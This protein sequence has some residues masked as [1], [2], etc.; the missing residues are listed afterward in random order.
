MHDKRKPMGQR[1]NRPVRVLLL[2]GLALCVMSC[3]ADARTEQQIRES[4]WLGA[5]C[6]ED[7]LSGTGGDIVNGLV[8][9]F[10]PPDN[11]KN[12][13]GQP[14]GCITKCLLKKDVPL[15]CAMCI[16]GRA[17]CVQQNCSD[18]CLP[19]GFPQADKTGCLKCVT[20]KCQEPLQECMGHPP[21]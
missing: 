12:N 5:E 10:L 9:C 17:H 13:G 1:L 8:Q 2:T 16:T 3:L 15:N 4:W 19:A 21:P 6:T 11:C 7:M 18:A 14:L 20:E